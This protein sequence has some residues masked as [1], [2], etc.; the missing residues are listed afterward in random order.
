MVDKEISKQQNNESVQATVIPFP[1]KPQK[2]YLQW[3]P[4]IASP[5]CAD[6]E[7]IARPNYLFCL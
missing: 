2:Q 6:G 4:E 5:V 7:V 1:H 3:R